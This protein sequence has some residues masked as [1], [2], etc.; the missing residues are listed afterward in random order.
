MKWGKPAASITAIKPDF[1]VREKLAT[2]TGG[3]AQAQLFLAARAGPVN[4]RKSDNKSKYSFYTNFTFCAFPHQSRMHM[5]GSQ[6]DNDPSKH[7][8]GIFS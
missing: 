2:L 1:S 4:T 7:L 3:K 8:A 5:P 6:T